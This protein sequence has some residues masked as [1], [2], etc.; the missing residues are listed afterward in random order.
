MA[1]HCVEPVYV[2]RFVEL[3]DAAREVEKP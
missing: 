1:M 3:I 2:R